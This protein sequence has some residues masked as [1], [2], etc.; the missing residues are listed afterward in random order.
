MVSHDIMCKTNLNFTLFFL[1]I[2]HTSNYIE[3]FEKRH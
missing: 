2:G 3:W 1:K